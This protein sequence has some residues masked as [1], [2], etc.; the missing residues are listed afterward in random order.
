MKTQTLPPSLLVRPGPRSRYRKLPFIGPVLDDLLAWLRG[1]NYSE[2]TIRN[3]LRATGTLFRWLPKRQSQRLSERDLRAAYDRFHNRYE[4]VA[5]AAHMLG[6]FLAERRLLRVERPEPLS[7]S[8][9]QLQFF[10]AYLRQVRGLADMTVIGHVGRIRIFFD[11]LQLD[12]HPSVI[13]TL[14]LEQIDAFL[15]K[16]ARTNNRFSLQHI[17]ASL[18]AFLRHQHARGYLPQPLHLHI[19]MPRTY[20]LE[21]LPRAPLGTGGGTASLN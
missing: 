8:Q 14:D 3:Y 18:R 19:D 9:K 10:E 11:F 20:R 2:W 13:R 1:Q 5:A 6:R 17:V 21:R 12:E 15:R 7:P 16:A 4:N